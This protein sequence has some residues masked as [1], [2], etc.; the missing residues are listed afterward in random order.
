MSGSDRNTFQI[1]SSDV[2]G[3]VSQARYQLEE[4]LAEERTISHQAKFKNRQYHVLADM[5]QKD[6][7]KA[8]FRKPA[9]L[10]VPFLAGLLSCT[11]KIFNG[12]KRDVQANGVE[13]YTTSH[14]HTVS[15]FLARLGSPEWSVYLGTWHDNFEQVMDTISESD[16]AYSLRDLEKISDD[17]LRERIKHLDREFPRAIS[18]PEKRID[19]EVTARL[20]ED[21]YKGLRNR[22]LSVLAQDLRQIRRRAGVPAVD[23]YALL[24]SLDAVTRTPDDDYGVAINNIRDINT[25][26]RHFTL[27]KPQSFLSNPTELRHFYER[28]RLSAEEVKLA[29]GT[30]NSVTQE[31][32][33]LPDVAYEPMSPSQASGLDDRS[34][35][36]QKRLYV[37]DFAKELLLYESKFSSELSGLYWGV[38]MQHLLLSSLSAEDSM[39][40]A[41][42]I[43]N[44]YGDKILEDP[45]I[46]EVFGIRGGTKATYG[47][48]FDRIENI[49]LAYESYGLLSKVTTP[50]DPEEVAFAKEH[51]IPVG[52]MVNRI[53]AYS[54]RKTITT[55]YDGFQQP[56][57]VFTCFRDMIAFNRLFNSYLGI[58]A[59][60]SFDSGLKEFQIQGLGKPI[61]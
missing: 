10:N 43:R 9:Q 24:L 13:L 12:S 23:A 18:T 5:L 57:G 33:I 38:Y 56:M 37:V 44:V 58:A 54:D 61:R 8:I 50:Y 14:S 36:L 20:F 7:N 16:Y 21:D 30:H 27:I 59:D 22:V 52:G 35:G 11:S 25:Y 45:H 15:R 28:V 41:K 26:A 17:A 4:L 34:K 29:D 46:K 32:A 2:S 31:Q 60:G 47:E 55:L 6:A 1:L 19:K 48:I 53:I 49:V 40:Q 42:E 3:L 51:H 39:R